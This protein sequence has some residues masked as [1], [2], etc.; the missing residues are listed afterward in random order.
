MLE[1]ARDSRIL[2][3]IYL[4]LIFGLV[5]FKISR[6]LR[7][8][9]SYRYVPVSLHSWNYCIFI[10]IL[11]VKWI[12]IISLTFHN[13]NIFEMIRV[14]FAGNSVCSASDQRWN[15]WYFNSTAFGCDD[16]GP[17][18]A[19]L[20]VLQTDL[21]IMTVIMNVMF[22]N[23]NMIT[24]IVNICT[25]IPIS[26]RSSIKTYRKNNNKDYRFIVNE[27]I[28]FRA[29]NE[30]GGTGTSSHKL[31]RK[32]CFQSILPYSITQTSLFIVYPVLEKN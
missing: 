6:Y 21:E 22:Q 23:V 27:V 16:P 3:R 2:Y 11:K 13:V 17:L 12:G 8:Q 32:R 31:G 24:V 20:G 4:Y 7:T 29:D 10:R 9:T 19:L 14:T 26:N 28:A 15:E 25:A 1:L 18:N 30:G 5:S